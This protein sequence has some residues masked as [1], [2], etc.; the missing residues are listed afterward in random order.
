M[1]AAW[2]DAAI[3]FRAGHQQL[4]RC[5]KQSGRRAAR[6]PCR[7]PP[8]V[9]PAPTLP[10]RSLPWSAPPPLVPMQRLIVVA[11]RLPVSAYKDRNGH[12]QLQVGAACRHVRFV[13]PC[14]TSSRR[15]AMLACVS[16]PAARLHNLACCCHRVLQQG[17]AGWQPRAAVQQAA[18]QAAV[19]MWM[20]AVAMC[21]P[22]LDG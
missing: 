16:A 10:T 19:A 18:G 17:S 15:C 2:C 11:N 9:P 3:K 1:I 13:Q 14:K 8:H 6:Q 12:W 4:I 5:D 7:R 22:V 21:M 20:P